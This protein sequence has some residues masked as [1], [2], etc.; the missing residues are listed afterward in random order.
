VRANRCYKVTHKKATKE[1]HASAESSKITAEHQ[2]F[3]G[4][5][6]DLPK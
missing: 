1:G 4:K 2:L 5:H 3:N 6:K